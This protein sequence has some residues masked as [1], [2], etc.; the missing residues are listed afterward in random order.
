MKVQFAGAG[1]RSVVVIL[2]GG[3]AALSGCTQDAGQKRADLAV[4]TMADTRA[5]I[6]KAQNQIYGTLNTLREIQKP[7]SDLK[8]GFETLK[9]QIADIRAQRDVIRDR[10]DDMR[11]RSAAYQNAWRDE[12]MKITDP[13]LQGTAKE[14]ADDVGTMYQQLIA[15]ATEAKA[16]YEPF[17]RKLDELQTYLSNDLT[18]AGVEKAKPS[19]DD[20]IAQGE[21]LHAKVNDLVREM[22]ILT[23]TM[24][25]TGKIPNSR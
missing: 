1:V 22:N 15:D 25:P 21:T 17:I 2:L 24:S 5:E 9:T 19:F 4:N 13:T 8:A 23:A 16:D 12:I 18:R 20:A 10:G 7:A 14:R 3:L 6:V 11:T